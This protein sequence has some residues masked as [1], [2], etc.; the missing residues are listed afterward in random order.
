VQSSQHANILAILTGIV[1]GNEASELMER[2]LNDKELTQAAIYF[3]Y[4]RNMALTMSGDGR[5]I[6]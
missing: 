6:S 2:L 4:Y 3:N 1:E 5:P